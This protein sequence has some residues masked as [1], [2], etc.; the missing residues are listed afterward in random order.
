MT[1]IMSAI[2]NSLRDFEA[3][4]NSPIPTP[5]TDYATSARDQ[6]SQLGD[7]PTPAQ[8]TTLMVTMLTK[9]VHESKQST[10]LISHHLGVTMNTVA[11]HENK[12][13]ELKNEVDVHGD[14]LNQFTETQNEILKRMK[15]VEQKMKRANLAAAEQ[16]QKSLKGNFIISG[17]MVPNQTPGE[18]L[19]QILFPTIFEKYGVYIYGHELK[20]LHRLPNNRVVFTILTR[21]LGRTLIT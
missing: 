15:V 8:L 19:Y 12:I 4:L 5:D 1:T 16:Q 20:A 14:A 6:V 7:T 2:S 11:Q 13:V 18:D 21:L 9:T 17:D 3:A 10:K